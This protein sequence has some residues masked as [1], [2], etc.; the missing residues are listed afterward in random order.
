MRDHNKTSGIWVGDWTK[1]RKNREG[2]E[3][4]D[5]CLARYFLSFSLQPKHL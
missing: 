2:L 4:L 5:L 3:W 1:G